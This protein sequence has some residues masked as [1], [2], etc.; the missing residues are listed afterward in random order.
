FAL[1]VAATASAQ[2]WR[3]TARLAGVVTDPSGKPIAG[4]RVRLTTQRGSGGPDVIKT[5]NKGRWVAGGLVDGAWNIDIEADGYEKKAGSAD[6]S[7]RQGSP[8]MKTVLTPAAKTEETTVPMAKE[9]VTVGGVE[10]TPET[11][12]ALEA[13]NGYMKE[14]KWVEA[15]AE[16]EKALTALPDNTS[17]KMALAR[18]YYGSGD[19]KKAIVPLRDVYKADT[20]NI[21]AATLFA[22]MLA[23]DGQ[24]EEAKKV[25]DAMPPGSLTDPT[26][27]INIGIL[28]MNKGKA[29]EAWGYFDKAVKIA[30]EAAETYYYRALAA[31]QTK[32]S[33][34]ARADLKKVM[35]L[36]PNGPEAKDAKDLLEQM[37]QQQQ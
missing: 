13:A 23:E 1:L 3:G 16:Y 33:D 18:A 12:A 34:A 27:I 22:N 11:A 4:A 24:L 6:V 17:L 36:A 20:G 29:D 15:A 19:V 7:E 37:Q 32:K 10:I 8:L 25:L 28:F 21:T 2:A 26:A 35:E 30:P 9:A 5:D 14:Q 31:L